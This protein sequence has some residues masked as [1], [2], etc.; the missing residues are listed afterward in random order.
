MEAAS[1]EQQYDCVQV[2]P[3]LPINKGII[4]NICPT[5]AVDIPLNPV[6][7]VGWNDG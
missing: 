3:M 7:D 4:D 5:A 6:Y 2:C 1:I